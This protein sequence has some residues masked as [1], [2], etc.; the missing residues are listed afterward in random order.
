MADIEYTRRTAVVRL[1]VDEGARRLLSET[2][3]EW[4]RGCQLAVNE[5]WGLCHTRS[6]V[7]KLAYDIVR[8]KTP[9]GSQHAVLAT[10]QAAESIKQRQEVDGPKPEFSGPSVVYD[11]RTM[12]LF[13]DDSVSLTT[14][15]NRVRCPLALPED[16]SA[17]PHEYLNDD[18]WEAAKTALYHRDGEFYLHLGFRKE[19]SEV[20]LP[21][22]DA[23]VLGVSLGTRNLAV[24][25]TARFFP[26]TDLNHRQRE[27]AD[28]QDALEGVGTRSA[29]RTLR[30][31]GTR[32]E[33]HARDRLHTI[34]NEIVEEACRY[35][36]DAIAFGEIGR[37][38]EEL[39]G[40]EPYHE[41]AFQTLFQFVEY[42]AAD[43]GVGVVEVN[44]E[45][46]TQRCTDCGF[47]HPQNRDLERN[48][49][50]CLKCGYE[51]QDDYNAAKNVG[52]RCIRRG[53]LSSSG[54]N[55]SYCTLQSGRVTPDGD[56]VPH[57]E[58]RAEPTIEQG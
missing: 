8:E 37:V 42:K 17:Y 22:R 36:V 34:A 32:T 1:E 47:T 23:T 57:P 51:Q 25:S 50:T 46:T 11:T 24:T 39:P 3:T 49:F 41:W 10:H 15:E 56:I 16:E 48:H 29:E 31:A 38:L 7:Q 45:Y 21:E 27:F 9:L 13:D 6:D 26:A 19:K 52:F 55:A 14:V 4:N 33:R 35:G 43:H 40:A 20:E 12:T 44:P 2:I 53:P 30:Q 54:I 18:S 5:A 58:P 28:V